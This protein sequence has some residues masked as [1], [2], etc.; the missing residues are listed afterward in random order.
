[1]IDGLKFYTR[2]AAVVALFLL[3]SYSLAQKSEAGQKPSTYLSNIG[4]A[5]YDQRARTV[6]A[7]STRE[8]AERRQNEVRKKIL[9]LI[10]GLP[11]SHGPV[12][13]K[14]YGNV[15]ADGFRVE[16]IAYESLPNYYVTADVYVPTSGKRPFPAV[17]VTPGNGPNSKIGEANWGA[18][19]ARNG[20]ITLSI[21]TFRQ[22]E[23]LQHYDPALEASKV[24]RSGE[25]E[26]A[27][28]SAL[29]IGDHVSRYFVKR[30]HTRYRLSYSTQRRGPVAYRSVRLFRGRNGDGAP[31]RTGPARERHRH[32]LLR[33]FAERIDAR[34]G[35]ARWGTNHSQLPGRRA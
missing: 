30:R 14:E 22:G 10:G 24:E 34:H 7:I 17:V 6:A 13:V 32:R 23:R 35:S 21:D 9:E 16:K 27:S 3:P 12:K 33:Y 26:H 2:A 29:L 31:R 8:E 5:Q 25:H 28:L 11:E 1:M 19:F 20:V 15:A 18:N 4:A